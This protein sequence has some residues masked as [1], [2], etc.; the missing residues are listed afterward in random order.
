MMTSH[1][2]TNLIINKHSNM[3]ESVSLMLQG[4]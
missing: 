1:E 3:A 2:S 4:Y